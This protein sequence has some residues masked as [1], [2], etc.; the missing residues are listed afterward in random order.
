MDH[1][2]F[3]FFDI[4]GFMRPNGKDLV[5]IDIIFVKKGSKLRPDFFQFKNAAG[6][7]VA[8]RK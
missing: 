1:K 6:D 7:V 4:A 2:G 8:E 5:Q 3:L